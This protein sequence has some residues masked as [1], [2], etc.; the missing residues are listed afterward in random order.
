M[1]C[2]DPPIA[3]NQPPEGEWYCYI[4]ASKR[5]PPSKPARGLFSGLLANLE[6][7]NPVAYNLPLEIRDYFEGVK[8][9]EEGEYEETVTQKSR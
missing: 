4:C 8:T 7:K 6:K 1:T 3:P 9:G 5:D 2:L